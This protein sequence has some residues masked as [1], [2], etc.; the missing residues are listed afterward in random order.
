[1]QAQRVACPASVRLHA[2]VECDCSVAAVLV[3]VLDSIPG[4]VFLLM[5]RVRLLL[6]WQPSQLAIK[7]SCP[8]S[9]C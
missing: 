3:V 6:R 9:R 7:P 2:A 4:A 5:S 8:S 1:M